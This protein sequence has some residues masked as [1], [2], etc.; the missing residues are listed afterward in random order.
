MN[1]AILE[2]LETILQGRIK[3]SHSGSGGCINDAAVIKLDNE[4]QYFVKT[5]DRSPNRMFFAEAN[6]LR[7]IGQTDSVAVPDVV[8]VAREFLVLRYIDSATQPQDF[9]ERM[10][11]ELAQM[12]RTTT[13]KFGFDEANFLGSTVQRNEWMDDWTA[14]WQEHRFG[15]Q[16][17]LVRQNGLADQEFNRLAD[18]IQR[19]VE[20][21]LKTNERPALVHGDLWSGNYMVGDRG[22]PIFIDPA[23]YF[24]HREVEFGMTTLFG[25]FDQT[26]YDAYNEEWP[27]EAG[28]EERIELYRLYHLLNH[29]NLFG[30]SYRSG[31][32]E[33]MKKYV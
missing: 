9:F 30:S 1:D 5:N 2:S 10:G 19:R 7:A 18:G 17:E 16:F 33:I 11:R 14:F 31:C 23:V 4:Q 20:Q 13:Q 6:G 15:F 25:G 32:V 24:G 22:Q 27:L 28:S 12:H 3:S 26:F 21:T 8:H 29:L